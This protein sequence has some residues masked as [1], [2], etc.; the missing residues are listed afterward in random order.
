MGLPTPDPVSGEPVTVPAKSVYSPNE[1]FAEACPS[2]R[3][4]TRIL[5]PVTSPSAPF[6]FPSSHAIPVPQ[7]GQASVSSISFAQNVSFPNF[8]F[9]YFL[10]GSQGPHFS[11]ASQGKLCDP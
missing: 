11:I 7:K 2:T 1:N 10:Q 9:V 5:V 4:V 6:I 3:S 8:P